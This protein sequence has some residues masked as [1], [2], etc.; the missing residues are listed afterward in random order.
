MIIYR[1][2]TLTTHDNATF[3]LYVYISGE[4]P[5]TLPQISN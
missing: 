4:F 5:G 2:A 1:I 3:I